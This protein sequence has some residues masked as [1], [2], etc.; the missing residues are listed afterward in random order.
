MAVELLK[1]KWTNA[2]NE[3]TIGATKDNGGT[4]GKTV[5]VGGQTTLPFMNSEGPIPNKPVIAMEVFDCEPEE[6][7]DVLKKAYGNVIKDP[8]EWARY[9]VVKCQADLLCITLQSTHPDYGNRRPEDACKLLKDILKEVAVPLI[10]VGSGDKEKDNIVL[11]ECTQAVKGENCLFGVAAQDNYKTLAASC[12][13]D[14]H[15]II[16]ES[17]IDIN[18]AKQVNILISDMGFDPKRIIMHPSTAALGYGME[19]VYSI[20]E[21]ARLAALT[22]DKMLAMPF[23]LFV[24]QEVWRVKE[25][26]SSG[27]DAGNWGDVSNRGPMWEAITAV[28]MF[29]AGADIVVLRHPKAVSSLKGYV[30]AVVK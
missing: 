26:S 15:L 5:T 1:N 23:I 12:M 6:W 20:M 18:I 11:A 27:E 22:G 7:P 30:S 19:Y 25:S 16:A 14:D 24:G 21:R 28:S 2:I 4:R 29:Q 8:V 9:C 10:I 3:V 13:A 17:P